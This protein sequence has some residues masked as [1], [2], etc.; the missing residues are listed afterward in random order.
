[1]RGPGTRISL[2]IF[3]T[4]CLL[5]KC[6]NCFFPTSRFVL[7]AWILYCLVLSAS[8]S[9]ALKSSLIEPS[10][11]PPVS[12]LSDLAWGDLPFLM[13][14][15]ESSEH[16]LLAMSEDPVRKRLWERKVPM[17]DFLTPVSWV[18]A[19]SNGFFGSASK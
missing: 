13:P 2:R 4:V 10:L 11:E 12:T 8:F 19:A 9:S 3:K 15:F 17:Y 16:T 18:A 1:M 14:M 5:K 7:A 6:I